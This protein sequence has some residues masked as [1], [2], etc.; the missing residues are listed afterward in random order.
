[1][2]DA[3]QPPNPVPGQC[4]SR[5]IRTPGRLGPDI[6]NHSWGAGIS[7]RTSSR[8]WG[9]VRGWKDDGGATKA[10]GHDWQGEPQ[11]QGLKGPLSM[12]LPRLP[13]LAPSTPAW[14]WHSRWERPVLTHRAR[15]RLPEEGLEVSS[16][17]ELQQDKSGQGLQTHPDTAH[18]VLVV[19]FAAE[20]KGLTEVNRAGSGE[21]FGGRSWVQS[22]IFGSPIR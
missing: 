4:G 8:G 9:C 1:M 21:I 19:E 17:H 2:W 6:L 13:A 3:Q 18:D 15:A 7:G 10:W 16:C 20:Q 5:H 12:L 14:S 11:S 22:S